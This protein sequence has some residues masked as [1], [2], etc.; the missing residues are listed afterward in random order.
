MSKR[1]SR[2]RPIPSRRQQRSLKISS[3]SSLSLHS[4]ECCTEFC[5]KAHAMAFVSATAIKSGR[6]SSKNFNSNTNPSRHSEDTKTIS[7]RRSPNVRCRLSPASPDLRLF[8]SRRS[9]S[10]RHAGVFH[11]IL[12]RMLRSLLHELR[13]RQDPQSRRKIFRRFS[14][15]DRST[16]RFDEVQFS[17]NEVAA[18]SRS[19]RRRHRSLSSVQVRRGRGEG[20][21]AGMIF[22]LG[23]GLQPVAYGW[24]WTKG[25]VCLDLDVVVS[26]V[27][28]LDSWKNA[29]WSSTMKIFM[30]EFRMMFPRTNVGHLSSPRFTF[31]SVLKVRWLSFVLIST[32]RSWMKHRNVSIRFPFFLIWPARRSSRSFPFVFWSIRRCASLIWANPFRISFRTT[33][34]S[35]EDISTKSFDWFDP[36]FFSNGI[37]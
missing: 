9:S 36:T 6:R 8:R 34:Y 33:L 30:S 12:R 14:P 23:G 19:R 16:S 29:P 37:K 21:G 1:V 35:A 22:G 13:L 31:F 32:I 25:F 5:W 7:S 27:T 4:R 24:G 26:S 18:L 20:R 11:A 2:H 3:L 28:S 15:L 17:P 10:R